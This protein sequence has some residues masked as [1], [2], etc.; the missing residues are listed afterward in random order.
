MEINFNLSITEQIE[1]RGKKY[2]LKRDDLI[3]PEFSGN[4]ARK[5]YSFFKMDLTEYHTLVSYGGNQSNAMFSLSA[6]AKLKNKKFIYYTRPIPSFLKENPIG[7]FKYALENGMQIIEKLAYNA[8]EPKSG[9]F[10]I[11]QGGADTY[12]EDGIIHLANEINNFAQQTGLSNL[13]VFLPSGTGATALY[14]QKNS[15]FNIYT[16]ACVGDTNYLKQQFSELEPN[17]DLHPKILEFENK[18]AF[19]KPYQEFI[20][21]WKEVTESTGKPFDL[22]YDPLGWLAVEKYKEILGENVVYIQCGGLHG[23]ETM[24]NRYRRKNW[25]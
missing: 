22:L 12:A 23:N 16:C 3:H 11:K 9:E 24:F 14:L 8:I 20:N 17:T 2:F 18:Y 4:K 21:L 6:L 19:G 10:L 25:L 7:N 15:P 5:F 13:S 1:F